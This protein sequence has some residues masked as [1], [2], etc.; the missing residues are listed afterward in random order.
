MQL[1][2]TMSHIFHNKRKLICVQLYVRVR[3]FQ[4]VFM[5]LVPPQFD[6]PA[7]DFFSSS[8]VRLADY[9]QFYETLFNIFSLLS[10]AVLKEQDW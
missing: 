7:V 2:E 5:F 10:D 1:A 3:D 4:N 8:T 6:L 9:F